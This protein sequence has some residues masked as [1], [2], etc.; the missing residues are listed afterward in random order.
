[1]ND[2][3]EYYEHTTFIH[4]YAVLLVMSGMFEDVCSNRTYGQAFLR[5]TQ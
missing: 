4:L 2:Q 1:M 5:F 3:T